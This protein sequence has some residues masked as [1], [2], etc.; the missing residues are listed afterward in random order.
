MIDPDRAREFLSHR[1]VAVVGASDDARNFG[2]TV[3]RALLEH[4]YDAVPVN[5]NQATVAGVGCYPD[6]A[7]IPG[8]VEAV[9]VMV[10]RDKS[11][12]VVRAVARCRIP[13]VWLFR[14]IG[15]GAVSDDAVELGLKV[16]LEVIA[17][18]CPLM[19]LPPVG[20]IHRV[21][22]L[23][24]RFSGTLAKSAEPW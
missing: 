18:G 6:L 21:H 5:P 3:L 19:F 1:R 14:G 13:R 17:G 8:A 7:S 10:G 20:G 12:Q 22:R 2:G 24:S 23:L 4:G 15:G 16:G 11:R 9:I